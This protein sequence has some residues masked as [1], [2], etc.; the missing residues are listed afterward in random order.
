MKKIVLL[1][2]KK[3]SICQLLLNKDS[4]S[5]VRLLLSDNEH[6]HNDE[7]NIIYL[8]KLKKVS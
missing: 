4:L 1:Q 6:I 8:F 7:D 3:C 2:N 5:R